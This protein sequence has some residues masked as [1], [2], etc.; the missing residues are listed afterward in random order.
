M[1]KQRSFT[2][3]LATRLSIA[4]VIGYIAIFLLWWRQRDSDLNAQI[5]FTTNLYLQER[6]DE[7]KTEVEKVLAYIT[8]QRSRI[9]KRVED[10]IR[11]RVR[12]A[13]A[14]AEHIYNGPGDDESKKKRI[15]EALRKIRFNDGRGYF[16]I[17]RLDG[18]NVLL[19][20]R[21]ELENTDIS[22]TVDTQGRFVIKDLCKIAL[23]V[24]EGFYR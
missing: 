24:G 5:E 17:T 20:D 7:I 8:Y 10:N 15:V 9:E 6:K 21:P 4:F 13:Y 12:E 14:V 23:N 3:T 1:P 16:F 18:V 22:N 19:D 11:N 2:R